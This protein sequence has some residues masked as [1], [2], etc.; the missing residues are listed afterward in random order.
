MLAKPI[1]T[2]DNLINSGCASFSSPSSS[3]P[4]RMRCLLK[5]A[6]MAS[7]A[8]LATPLS[9]VRLVMSTRSRTRSTG[10][11]TTTTSRYE[12]FRNDTEILQSSSFPTGRTSTAAR[13]VATEPALMR[14]LHGLF[15]YPLYQITVSHRKL[16]GDSTL[17]KHAMLHLVQFVVWHLLMLRGSVSVFKFKRLLHFD[18]VD[19]LY[20][21]ETLSEIRLREHFEQL[22]CERFHIHI[23]QFTTIAIIFLSS[24]FSAPS[25]STADPNYN[26]RV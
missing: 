8:P 18:E 11:H 1:F 20:T 5:A 4:S 10:G 9:A 23:Q 6:V 25:F 15:S 14:E 24:T 12:N 13:V 22:R 16:C 21:T 19:D 2:A 17:V 3:F 7:T 26:S